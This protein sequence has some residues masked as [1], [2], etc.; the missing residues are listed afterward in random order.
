MK[1]NKLFKN[2]KTC[3]YYKTYQPLLNKL[4][5]VVTDTDISAKTKLFKY[6]SGMFVKIK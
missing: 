3:I 6:K 4:K 1:I 2:N 5:I